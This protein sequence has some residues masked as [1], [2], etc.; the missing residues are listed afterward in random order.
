MKYYLYT[1]FVVA[2]ITGCNAKDNTKKQLAVKAADTLNYTYIKWV[3]SLKDIGNIPAGKTQS[4]SFTFMN[5]G[6]KPLY[7]IDAKPGCGCT[8]ADYPKEAILPGKTGVLKADYN[9][10]ENG[11]GDFRKSI[12]VTTNTKDKTDNYIFFYGTIINDSLHKEQT[13]KSS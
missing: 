7:I 10:H 13:K 11:Q 4:I 9:V 3:D 12:R 8:L 6:N 5:T 2:F 1:F